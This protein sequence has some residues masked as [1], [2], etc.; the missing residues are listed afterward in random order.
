[1]LAGKL[2]PSLNSDEGGRTDEVVA[3]KM[4]RCFSFLND[5]YGFEKGGDRKSKEKVF[6]LKNSEEPKTQKELA[7]SHGITQ[8][9]MQR[10]LMTELGTVLRSMMQLK[11]RIM[12][13]CSKMS[14]TQKAVGL[15][16]SISLNWISQ[17]KWQ[18]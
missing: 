9:T 2:D 3:R 13:F 8:Q 7:E 10:L 1:M 15:L 12:R 4:G 16:R 11:V 18:C 5:Y 14:G 17:R 6:P